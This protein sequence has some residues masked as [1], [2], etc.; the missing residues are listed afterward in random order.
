MR[1]SPEMQE[2]AGQKVG[3]AGFVFGGEVGVIKDE[4]HG[5]KRKE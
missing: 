1:L 2:R 3:T 4:E 5:E